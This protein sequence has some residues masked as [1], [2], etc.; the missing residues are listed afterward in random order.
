MGWILDNQNSELDSCYPSTSG[1]RIDPQGV[2]NAF[3]GQL[4]LLQCD[5]GEDEEDHSSMHHGEH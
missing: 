4:G 1:T 5:Q 2:G 3:W